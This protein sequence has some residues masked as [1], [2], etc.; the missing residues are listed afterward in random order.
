MFIISNVEPFET[1]HDA[2]VAA[3]KLGDEYSVYCVDEFE[4]EDD[5]DEDEE[6]ED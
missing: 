2:E 1:E 3:E 4:D 5:E 6:D